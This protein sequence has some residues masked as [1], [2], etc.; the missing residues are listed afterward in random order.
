[1]TFFVIIS[2]LR[3]GC[4]VAKVEALNVKNHHSK[5]EKPYDL[6]GVAKKRPV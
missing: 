4:N 6:W 5:E 1:M 3:L 2:T